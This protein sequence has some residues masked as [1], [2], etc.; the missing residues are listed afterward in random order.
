MNPADIRYATPWGMPVY[1]RL[2]E[3]IHPFAHPERFRPLNRAYTGDSGFWEIPSPE[4]DLSDDFWREAREGLADG[5]MPAAAERLGAALRDWEPDPEKLVFAAILRAGVPVADWLCRLL[6]GSRA[7]ALSLFAGLGI[8]A[9]ALAALK[10][11]HP[12][13]R[14]VF[15]DGWTGRG[16]VAR[17]IRSLNEGPLAVLVDPWGWADFT[18]SRRDEFCPSACF[19]GLATLGFSRT[20]ITSRNEAFCAYRFPDRWLREDLIAAWQA[21][22]PARPA[23][24]FPAD[25]EAGARS[26]PEEFF[27]ETPLR[28]HANEVCR[29]LINAAPECLYFADEESV[30]RRDFSLLLSLAAHRSLPAAFASDIPA[31]L[32]TR[33]ACRLET[34]R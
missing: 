13:R 7:A 28:I 20:F 4:P 19:T 22:C 8:D 1:A 24:I 3:E 32:R 26:A 27:M 18:G 12:G 10:A 34:S 15:V 5:E 17:L 21:A 2:A 33:V 23:E 9:I 31:P 16:G 14:V 6:P 11:D 30:A 29:A 25:G